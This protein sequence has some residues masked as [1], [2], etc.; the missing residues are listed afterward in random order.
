MIPNPDKSAVHTTPEEFE[1]AAL[2]LRLYYRPGDS[3]ATKMER[4]E[5]TVKTG[6]FKNGS[7]AVFHCGQKTLW[8]RKLFENNNF[9]TISLSEFSNTQIQ[10]ET[11]SNSSGVEWTGA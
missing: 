11:F 7:F 5:N 10:I 6:E 9:S 4:F 1:D 8:K 2:F 3:S